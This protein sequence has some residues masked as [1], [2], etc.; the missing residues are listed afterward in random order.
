MYHFS[1]DLN[2]EKTSIVHLSYFP[3]TTSIPVEDF[4]NWGTASELLQTFFSMWSTYSLFLSFDKNSLKLFG[5][6][7]AG[8]SSVSWSPVLLSALSGPLIESSRYELVENLKFF[9]WGGEW[10]GEGG[11]GG[12]FDSTHVVHI[13]TTSTKKGVKPI[14]E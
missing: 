11:V 9:F 14:R 7:I 13:C 5:I 6:L 12:P 2:T 4:N 10:G 3:S 8:P 1:L